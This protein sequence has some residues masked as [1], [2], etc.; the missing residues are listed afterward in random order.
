MPRLQQQPL[1]SSINTQFGL[2]DAGD[3]PSIQNHTARNT[4]LAVFLCPS[5]GDKNHLNTYRFNRGRYEPFALGAIEDGPFAI[6]LLPSQAT[7]TDRLSQTVF[8]SERIGGPNARHPDRSS[9]R[10]SVRAGQDRHRRDDDN[11]DQRMLPIDGRARILQLREMQYDLV[12][13]NMPTVHYRSFS[14][15][16]LKGNNMEN[17]T[18]ASTPAQLYLLHSDH[19][20]RALALRHPSGRGVHPCRLVCRPPT[21]LWKTRLPISSVEQYAATPRETRAI[22]STKFT[23]PR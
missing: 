23:S 1:F 7:I 16:R 17:G 15:Q 11:T 14:T 19:S 9:D 21:K 4:R 5:D 2:D 3:A 6:G 20:K 12:Q 18:K 22:S 13:G 10:G 8:A